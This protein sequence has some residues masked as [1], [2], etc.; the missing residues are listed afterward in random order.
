MA[1]R[2]SERLQKENADLKAKLA[3]AKTDKDTSQLETVRRYVFVY[4]HPYLMDSPKQPAD[5]GVDE[6]LCHLQYMFPNHDQA[7]RVC[8]LSLLLLVKKLISQHTDCSVVIYSAVT[9][10][11]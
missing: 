5:C 7:F 11:T 2:N 4:L 8:S 1:Q 6:G 3:L 9:V 10:Y